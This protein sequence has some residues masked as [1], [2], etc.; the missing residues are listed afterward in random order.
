MLDWLNRVEPANSTVELGLLILTTFKLRASREFAAVASKAV[1]NMGL[2]FPQQ[3]QLDDMIQ[4][5]PN[6]VERL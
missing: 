2:K 4:T 3:W 1:R 6:S 5:L